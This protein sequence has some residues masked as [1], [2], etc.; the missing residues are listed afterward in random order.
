MK[1]LNNCFFLVTDQMNYLEQ[2]QVR[3]LNHANINYWQYKEVKQ[4]Y[5]FQV[6]ANSSLVCLWLFLLSVL[7]SNFIVLDV[8]G[9]RKPQ[10]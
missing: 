4:L 2:I 6:V 9:S 10:I 5:Q 1:T 8:K 7:L 3:P